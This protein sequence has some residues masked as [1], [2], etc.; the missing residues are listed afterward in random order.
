MYMKSTCLHLTPLVLIKHFHVQ[1]PAFLVPVVDIF[2]GDDT[3]TTTFNPN[4]RFL[5]ESNSTAF[6]NFSNNFN[7]TL[8]NNQRSGNV[9][10]NLCGV[11]GICHPSAE[12]NC[13]DVTLTNCSD[14]SDAASGFFVFIVLCLGLAILFGNSLILG[15]SAHLWKKRTITHIDWYKASLAVADLMTGTNRYGTVSIF[16]S[17]NGGS[18]S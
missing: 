18:L 9:L 4:V 8:V 2:T 1:D 10:S 13:F 17:S 7:S 6:T 14:C 3:L 12:Q 5:D 16:I 11:P 15:V